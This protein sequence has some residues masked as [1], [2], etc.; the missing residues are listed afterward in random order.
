MKYFAKIFIILFAG[1]SISSAQLIVKKGTDEI[2]RC[3]SEKTVGIG[4]SDPKATLQVNQLNLVKS[5]LWPTT[6]GTPRDGV[7][8]IFL[9]V[10]NY[11]SNQLTFGLSTSLPTI[12][13]DTQ[14]GRSISAIVY[15]E[16]GGLQT[17][18]VSGVL[19]KADGQNSIYGL[20]DVGTHSVIGVFGQV[21][22]TFTDNIF[23]AAGY[24]NNRRQIVQGN[25][26]HYGLYVN[27]ERNNISGNLAVT[28]RATLGTGT[29]ERNL[30]ACGTPIQ[31]VVV[32]GADAAAALDNC[33]RVNSSVSNVHLLP[34]T[35]NIN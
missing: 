22:D 19:G 23:T 15:Q 13:G 32:I 18:I 25:D 33:Q 9:P 2:M 11:D 14:S 35:V 26:Q 4:T 24:F 10:E 5:G 31:G 30:Y 12:T 17:G 7:A 21:Y 16:S 8:S 1:I 20:G 6:V 3:T 28:E 27:A 34:I 29:Q